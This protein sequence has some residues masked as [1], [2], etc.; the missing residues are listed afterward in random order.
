MLQPQNSDERIAIVNGLI[1]RGDIYR[2]VFARV[3]LLCGALSL[4]TA[5][6]MYL[7][8]ERWRFLG[9]AIRPREFAFAWLDIFVLTAVGAMMFL[10]RVTRGSG[11]PFPSSRMKTVLGAMAPY[12]FIPS[13]F[14][15]WFFGTGYLGA[16]EY[17]LAVVWIASYGLMLLSL[18]LIAPRGIALLGWAFLLTALAGPVLSEKIDELTGNVPITLLG[19]AFGVFH[20]IYAGLNWRS[21]S[22]PQDLP[23]INQ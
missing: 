17:Q 12:V 13:L 10:W 7:N 1:A 21:G 3:A 19:V 16:A 5:V 11:D 15:A 6:V 20:V 4:V 2:A 22:R 8:D 9:R 18:S 14:T 23:P